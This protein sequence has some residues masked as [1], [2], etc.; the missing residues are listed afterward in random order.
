MKILLRESQIKMLIESTPFEV[1][2]DIFLKK[3]TQ[4]KKLYIF[5]DKLSPQERSQETFGLRKKFNEMGLKWDGRA[6]SGPY[7]KFDEINKLIKS[8]NKI[9]AFIEKIENL[10]DFVASDK[11]LP[12]DK[13]QELQTKIDLYIK[14]LL[15]ATDIAAMDAAIRNYLTFHS[16]FTRRSFYNTLLIYL[17]DPDATKVEGYRTWR[18]KFNRGVKK[19]ANSI[20]IWVPLMKKVAKDGEGVTN[21]DEKE[22]YGYTLGRVYDISDTYPLSSEGEIP[23][24]PQ[25]WGENTPSETADMLMV[26]L[27]EVAKDL[28]ITLTKDPA[29]DGEKGSSRGGHINLSSDIS[30]VGEASTMVHELAHE[31]LHWE[32][33]SPFYIED[34]YY[35]THEMRELQA[36]SV[37][38]IVMK[39][40]DLPVTHHPT[41]LVLS[42]A[43]AE[44]IKMNLEIITKCAHFIFEKIDGVQDEETEFE[45]DE[46]QTN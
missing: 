26:K 3:D 25:W 4:N 37:S 34:P 43:N 45:D 9:R 15:N 46:P 13:K 17:Q 23:Q 12:P 40:Y 2:E 27:R 6:W 33:K 22:L 16:K 8:H 39:H 30:G 28:N 14:D 7:E 1:K 21:N 18:K 10:E 32:K 42:K 24:T 41:Y 11:S 36:E 5:S 31:L 29:K 38:Y 44:K 19:G 20:I 35:R